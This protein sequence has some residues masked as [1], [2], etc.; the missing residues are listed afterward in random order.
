MYDGEAAGVNP[1]RQEKSGPKPAS[2]LCRSLLPV[3]LYGPVD[4]FDSVALAPGGERRLR[5]CSRA[6]VVV[7]HDDLVLLFRLH[8]LL[9]LVS[10]QAAAERAQHGGKVLT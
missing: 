2:E 6:P 1:R 4:D 3:R 8:A 5:E 10:A 7:A 9:D